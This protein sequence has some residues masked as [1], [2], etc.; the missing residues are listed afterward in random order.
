MTYGQCMPEEVVR[1]IMHEKNFHKDW[2]RDFADEWLEAVA[3]LKQSNIPYEQYIRKV[4]YERQRKKKDA[5]RGKAA[6]H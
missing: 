4:E 2:I 1:E 3:T 5:K 6:L